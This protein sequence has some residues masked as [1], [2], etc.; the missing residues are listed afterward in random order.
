MKFDT[1]IDA[2]FELGEDRVVWYER[3]Y[4]KYSAQMFPELPALTFNAQGFISRA[5]A[6]FVMGYAAAFAEVKKNLD[7][8]HKES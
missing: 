5:F 3:L 1:R 6:G 2:I 4:L 8:A 7:E